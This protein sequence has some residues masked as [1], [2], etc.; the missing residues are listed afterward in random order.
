MMMIVVQ[1]ME[2]MT[3][4]KTE[5]IGENCPSAALATTDPTLDLPQS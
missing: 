3:G 1:L 5:V 4:S 2:C